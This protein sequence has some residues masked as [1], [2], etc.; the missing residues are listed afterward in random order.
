M[1]DT[2]FRKLTED[3]NWEVSSEIRGRKELKGRL[4]LQNKLLKRESLQLQAEKLH[5]PDGALNCSI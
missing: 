5:V 3:S 4:G 2:S 1:E